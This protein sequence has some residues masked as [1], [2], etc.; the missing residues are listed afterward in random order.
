MTVTIKDVAKKQMLLLLLFRV[1]LRI[2]QVL[3]KK[4]S[5]VYVK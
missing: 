1:L 5:A 3:V 4:Q 2:I